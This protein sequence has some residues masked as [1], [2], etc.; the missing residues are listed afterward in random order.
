ML[1]Q[2]TVALTPIDAVAET[3]AGAASELAAIATVIRTPVFRIPVG[4]HAMSDR[5]R[6]EQKITADAR[7]KKH[8]TE[9]INNQ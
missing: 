7:S 5:G 8:M 3:G 6:E 1:C 4:L 9:R 2:S